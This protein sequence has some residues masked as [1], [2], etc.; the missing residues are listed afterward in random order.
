MIDLEPI[1]ARMEK[2]T[3]GP[4]AWHEKTFVECEIVCKKSHEAITREPWTPDGA[5]IVNA[6]ADIPALVAE[7][8]RLRSLLGAVIT[9]QICGEP[10]VAISPELENAIHNT[11]Q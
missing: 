10:D 2:A 4:W 8:E 3:K 6:R 11:L 1:K 9:E 7:V 5:F